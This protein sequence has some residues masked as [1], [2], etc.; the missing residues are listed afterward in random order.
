MKDGKEYAWVWCAGYQRLFTERSD[1]L[2]IQGN[3]KD[4]VNALC[5]NETKKV[6]FHNLKFDGQFLLNYFLAKGYKY[7]D[8]LKNEKEMSYVIDQTGTF[9]MLSIIFKNSKGKIRRVHFV[10]SMKIYPYSLKVLA[11]QMKME[12]GKGEM[13]YEILR[14]PNHKLTDAEYDYLDEIF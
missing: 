1:G 14:R 4:F 13:D 12:E 11:K 9:Y 7:N 5:Q 3:I 8:E 10:D 6:Y 2:K